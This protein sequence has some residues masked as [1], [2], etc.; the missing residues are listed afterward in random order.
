MYLPHTHHKLGIHCLFFSQSVSMF[1]DTV[2]L[3]IFT[4]HESLAR[5]IIFGYDSPILNHNSSLWE[6]CMLC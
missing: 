5:K 6:A 4:N 1:K 3:V 2:F